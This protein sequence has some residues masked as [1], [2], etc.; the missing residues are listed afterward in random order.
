MARI[1]V[2]MQWTFHND[3]KFGSQKQYKM[4]K[5]VYIQ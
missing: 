4:Y 1:L 5:F 2:D 3:R